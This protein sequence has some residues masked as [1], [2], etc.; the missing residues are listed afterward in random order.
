MKDKI[1][2]YLNRYLQNFKQRPI[3]ASFT[4]IFQIFFLWWWGIC[5]YFLIEDFITIVIPGFLS[6][7]QNVYLFILDNI[8]LFIV[9][10]YIFYR[11][12]PLMFVTEKNFKKRA[13]AYALSFMGFICWLFML[14]A[15]HSILFGT[16]KEV[17]YTFW[18]KEPQPMASKILITPAQENFVKDKQ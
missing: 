8:T 13:T 18:A 11:S 5:F 4:L 12:L 14:T 7:K 1:I 16:Y 15:P 9:C 6:G 3:A 17:A 10:G 2:N